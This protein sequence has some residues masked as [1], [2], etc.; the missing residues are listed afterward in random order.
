LIEFL[1][2]QIAA[3]DDNR[4]PFLA[5]GEGNKLLLF[6]SLRLHGEAP[7]PPSSY[8]W[9]DTTNQS[10]TI[11]C[12]LEKWFHV[13]CEVCPRHDEVINLLVEYPCIGYARKQ[14]EEI[15]IFVLFLPFIP[16]AYTC[17]SFQTVMDNIWKSFA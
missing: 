1:I 6:P 8:P 12:P 17:I 7:I 13:G 10:T 2:V 15:Y 14:Y 4:L 16:F 5:L 11:E 3:G 9:T